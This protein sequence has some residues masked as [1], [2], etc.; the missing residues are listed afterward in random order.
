VVAPIIVFTT[1][2]VAYNMLAE[3]TL[4]FLGYGV[5]PDVPTWGNMLTGADQFYMTVPLLAI[6]PGAALTIAILAVN[7]LGDG[8][9]DALDPRAIR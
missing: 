6:I 8:L 3:A 5:P 1:L 9:R 7:F 4:D 2:E